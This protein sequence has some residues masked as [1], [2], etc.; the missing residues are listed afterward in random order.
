MTKVRYCRTKVGEEEKERMGRSYGL[1]DKE[2][3]F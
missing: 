3:I 1:G 2:T